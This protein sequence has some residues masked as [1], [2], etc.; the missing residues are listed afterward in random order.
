[1]SPVL[2]SR[3][4]APL[5][6]A[7]LL[8]LGAP[9]AFASTTNAVALLSAGARFGLTSATGKKQFHEGE[10]YADLGLPW[11]WDSPGGWYLRPLLTAAAGGL[12]DSYTDGGLFK[13]GA[14]LQYGNQRFPVS[15]EVGFCPT[16]L[17]E[18]TYG[19]KDFGARLQFT[20]HVGLNFDITSRFRISYRLQH[21]SNGGLAVPNPGLNLHLVGCGIVF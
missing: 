6:C 15:L 17:T 19:T 1:M 11:R 10:F 5:A 9:T 8:L 4:A 7:G 12:G 20:S 14:G 13:A 2:F 16:L 3:R 21:M 18:Q